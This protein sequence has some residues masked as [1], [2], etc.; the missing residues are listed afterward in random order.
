[1]PRLQY[2]KGKLLRDLPV[3]KGIVV[4]PF[5]S[6][7]FVLCFSLLRT[8]GFGTQLEVDTPTVQEIRITRCRLEPLQLNRRSLTQGESGHGQVASWRYVNYAYCFQGTKVDH[9][10]GRKAGSNILG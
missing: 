10:C 6:S 5:S 7:D 8:F 4:R 1:M 9:C 3:V 2:D